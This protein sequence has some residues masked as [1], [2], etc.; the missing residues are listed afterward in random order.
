VTAYAFDS[1]GWYTGEVPDDSPNSTP[2][3]PPIT[4]TDKPPGAPRSVWSRV[5]WYTV[6]VPIPPTVDLYAGDRLGLWE[7]VKAERDRRKANGTLVAGKWFHSDA[8]SRIQQLGLFM[9]GAAVPSVP[10]KTM[11]GTFITMSQALAAAIFQ[12]TAANDMALFSHAE[13][14]RLQINNAPAPQSIDIK[15]GWPATFE[16]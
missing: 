14:L 16:G 2:I 12:A 5:A 10:W 7:K 13:S 4:D 9:M 1:Q 3:A 8:D 6:A 11:D 15:S